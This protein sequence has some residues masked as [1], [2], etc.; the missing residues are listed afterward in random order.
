MVADQE[1]LIRNLYYTNLAYFQFFAQQLANI[2]YSFIN[3]LFDYMYLVKYAIKQIA[4][5]CG[6]INELLRTN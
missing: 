3:S 2:G 5:S 4:W 1:I 6:F